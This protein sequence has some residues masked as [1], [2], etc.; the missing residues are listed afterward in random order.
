MHTSRGRHVWRATALVAALLLAGCTTPPGPTTTPEP[1]PGQPVTE[2]PTP[3]PEAPVAPERPAAMDQADVAGAE[4]LARYFLE[5]YPYVYATGDLTEWRAL[6][7]PECVFC[8]SVIDNVEA[9]VAAGNRSTGAE[10]TVQSAD[11]RVIDETWFAADAEITQAP[12]A[13][14]GP[15]GELLSENPATQSHRMTFSLIHDG[16]WLVRAVQVDEAPET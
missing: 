11:A 16:T 13:E 14:Y 9:Q 2:E 6:S 12:S 8:T 1:S 4:A 5:L 7:H 3:T 15:D 10:V